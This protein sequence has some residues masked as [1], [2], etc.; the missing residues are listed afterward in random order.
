MLI[1]ILD[2]CQVCEDFT[3]TTEVT[4]LL[5]FKQLFF[6]HQHQQSVMMHQEY[7][8]DL[9]KQKG[10]DQNST[11]TCIIC[12]SPTMSACSTCEE[13]VC[14]D[15]QVTHQAEECKCQP[16]SASVL[17]SVGRV[18]VAV[19]DI[20]PYEAVLTDTC[21]AQCPDDSP[22]CVGCLGSVTGETVCEGCKWPV[23]RDQCSK[24]EHHKEECHIFQKNKIVPHINNFDDNHWLYT[25]L[26]VLRV[27]LCKKNNPPGWRKVEKLM[28]HWE[29]RANDCQVSEGVR[30][31]WEF[32]Y[33]MCDLT[34]VSLGDVQHVFGVLKTNSVSLITCQGRCLY[35]TVSLL[36]HSCIPN[37]EP[38]AMPG[39]RITLRARTLIKAGEQLTIR[40]IQTMQAR[41]AIQDK[42]EQEWFFICG[43]K[44][45]KDATELGSHFSSLQCPCGGFF[46]DKTCNWYEFICSHCGKCQ[47]LSEKFKQVEEI[48]S[49]LVSSSKETI[50][51]LCK[52]VEDDL[53]IHSNFY[54]TLKLYMKY[55]DMEGTDDREEVLKDVILRVKSVLNT[56]Q[57]VDTG[58]SKLMGKY[59]MVL[60]NS[61]QKLLKKKR[62]EE[63]ISMHDL[64]QAAKE[65]TRLKLSAGRMLS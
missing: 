41:W 8:Q 1:I 14:E 5:T 63:E 29:E 56:L 64:K 53:M 62:S 48:E 43:C 36:S 47:D 49:K 32:F 31:M 46:S 30:R 3:S 26:A 52:F 9:E 34:W 65:L 22:V 25:A 27:L 44:R 21:L 59:L 39:T 38:V 35:P 45:C 61:Q 58:C 57:L 37:L 60:A 13:K 23:C 28:D 6:P 20:Q 40:Y 16:W 2:E 11:I 54:L 33:K 24:E 19:R 17:P 7:N 42:L 18:L 12:T 10:D 15:D 55:I 50:T 4:F 51:E